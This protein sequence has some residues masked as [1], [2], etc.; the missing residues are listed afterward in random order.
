MLT[1][2]SPAKINLALDILGKD[3]SGY[4]IM[5]TVLHEV[6]I[7]C[8]TL[9]FQK[10]FSDITVAWHGE[11]SAPPFT[12]N[13]IV[14]AAQLFFQHTKINGGVH[15]SIEKKIPTGAGLGGGSSNA[16]TTLKALN[17]IYE[18][19]LSHDVLR[20][21]GAQ[22]GMDVPFFI[23]GGTALGTHFGEIITQ[24]P[25]ARLPQPSFLFSDIL[26]STEKT[27]ATADLSVC[28]TKTAD[29]ERLVEL[30]RK[31]EKIPFKLFHNDFASVIRTMHPALFHTQTDRLTSLNIHSFG[32]TGASVSFFYF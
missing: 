11:Q 28:G 15:I 20:S 24:L 10:K 16:A 17:T 7:L 26:V 5:Q 2:K 21:I 1:L 4:H 9:S 25:L 23:D 8:D 27:Y 13:S 18:T 12:K 22:I 30:I 3:S 32:L 6:L 31:G 19:R 14:R 29:T